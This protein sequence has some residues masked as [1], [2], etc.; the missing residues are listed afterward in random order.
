MPEPGN[1]IGRLDF[2]AKSID[3]DDLLHTLRRATD[4]PDLQRQVQLHSG[5]DA[6]RYALIV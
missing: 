5:Q 4:F 3:M 6:A 2:V 1:A